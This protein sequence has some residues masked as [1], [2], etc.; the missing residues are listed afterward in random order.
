MRNNSAVLRRLGLVA[1]LAL[2][3]LG[4]AQL[5]GR[6]TEDKA[7]GDSPGMVSE[8]KLTGADQQETRTGS[9]VEKSTE[10]RKE[11]PEAERAKIP[12]LTS[13]EKLR[14]DTL[15][16]QRPV[17][18]ALLKDV[19]FDFDR[20]E[21]T[22]QNRDALKENAGWLKSHPQSH[23]EIEG[24]ADERGT[25]EYNLALGAKRSQ[26]VKDYLASLGIAP[27]RL[28]TISYGEEL[29]LCTEREETCW[30]KN[31]RAHFVLI[32]R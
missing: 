16:E 10:E 15:G 3:L 8:E 9:R 6:K 22:S 17:E 32:R 2:F 5:R 30:Q 29:P 7:V 1:V 26:T 4:C 21:L 19:H 18:K 24:H 20:Y 25:V 13:L 31:R 14:K 28:S 11:M 12:E 23:V 27:D